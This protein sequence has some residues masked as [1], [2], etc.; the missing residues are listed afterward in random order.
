MGKQALPFHGSVSEVIAVVGIPGQK[1]AVPSSIAITGLLDHNLKS[2]GGILSVLDAEVLI[3]IACVAC[4][5]VIVECK[6]T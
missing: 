2:L 6:H 4:D 1:E 3:L 5:G